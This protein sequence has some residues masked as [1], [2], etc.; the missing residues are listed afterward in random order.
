MEENNKIISISTQEKIQLNDSVTSKKISKGFGRKED[1]IELHILTSDDQL[2]HSEGNFTEYT[3]PDSSQESTPT[4]TYPEIIINPIEVLSKRG[5]V[6]GR[7]KIKL[8]I[9]RKKVFDSSTDPF[10]IKE[11]SPSRKE[12]RI[13]APKVSNEIFD[14][15]VKSFI[16]EIESSAYFRDFVLN[17]GRDIRALGINIL[18]NKN[19]NK[20]ELL[21][22]LL[23]PLP[24][25]I[26]DQTTLNIVE[27]IV[28][29]QI[30]D[31]DLGDPET[32]D[33]SIY[34]R[35]P[36]FKI[37]TRINNSIPSGFKNY[38]D[39]LEY[40]L[41]SSYQRL[42]NQLDNREIPSIDYD[43]VRP[44]SS[45]TED[46]DVTYHFENFVHFSNATERLKN[47]EYKVKLIEI[48]ESQIQSI[49]NVA[50]S[51]TPPTVFVSNGQSSGYADSGIFITD[52]SGPGDLND[53]TSGMIIINSNTGGT[54]VVTSLSNFG[55]IMF[56]NLDT[57]GNLIIQTNDPF[58]VL[59]YA[60]GTSPTDLETEKE[61]LEE[62]KLRLIGGFDGYE[63]F[64]YYETGSFATWPKKVPTETNTDIYVPFGT[65]PVETV[66]MTATNQNSSNQYGYLSSLNIIFADPP[67]G[68]TGNNIQ[69][70]MIIT[71]TTTGES[72][73]IT[74][75]I[76]FNEIEFS[77]TLFIG[78]N[79][80]WTIGT[81]F[82]FHGSIV[83]GGASFITDGVQVGHVINNLTT[84]Q[85]ATITEVN[86]ETEL[87]FS[88]LSYAQ[89]GIPF[90]AGDNFSITDTYEVPIPGGN[91]PP[92]E[93][94]ET[95]SPQA[96]AWLGSADGS[97]PLYGGQLLSASLF[98]K[99]NEHA[100]VNLV[101][102]HIFDNPDNDFYK[103]FV[104]MI[105]HH[106]DG[107]WTYIK[108]YTDINDTHH[109]RGISK[110]LVYFQLKS[111]GIETFD[112]FEN[113]NL[114]EYILGDNPSSTNVPT[115]VGD[116]TIGDDF[117]IGGGTGI[118]TSGN[119]L[120]VPA[121]QTLVTA[122][123]DGSI[124]K[125]DITKEIWKRLYHN[126]PHLLK[127][128]GTERGVKALMSCYGVPSTILNVKEYGGNTVTS[129]P[130]KNLDT[131]DYYKTFTY[132]K[133]SQALKGD[134]GADGF[135]VR[136][137]W[138][139][140]LGSTIT[141]PNY[142]S[143]TDPNLVSAKAHT[144]EFRIKP[145]RTGDDQILMCFSQSY[146]PDIDDAMIN[147]VDGL[148][149]QYM[150]IEPYSGSDILTTDDAPQYGKLVYRK[151]STFLPNTQTFVGETEYFPIYSGEWWNIHAGINIEGKDSG[152]DGG[153]L[154]QVYGPVTADTSSNTFFGAYRA[155]FL[156]NVSYYTGSTSMPMKSHVYSWGVGTSSPIE[157]DTLGG[158]GAPIAFPSGGASYMYICG[159][160]VSGGFLNANTSITKNA[161]AMSYS[162]S[163]QELRYYRGELLTH[164]T[165]IKHALEPFMYGGNSVSS[166]YDN[167]YLRLALGSND[168]QDSSSFH[169]NIKHNYLNADTN[170]QLINTYE[171]GGGV[172]GSSQPGGFT[173]GW[174]KG[175]DGDK[176]TLD[177]DQGVLK[178]SDETTIS[179][180]LTFS[181]VYLPTDELIKDNTYRVR[182]TM[183]NLKRTSSTFST[184]TGANTYF[185]IAPEF[186]A[187]RIYL[188]TPDGYQAMTGNLHHHFHYAEPLNALGD[189]K[190][191]FVPG[192][193]ERMNTPYGA[194]TNTNPPE[195]ILYPDCRLALGYFGL[196]NSS[197]WDYLG[198]PQAVYGEDSLPIP[199]PNWLETSTVQ[200]AN[201]VNALHES[202]FI[203][204]GY[205]GMLTN[206][207]INQGNFLM[208]DLSSNVGIL[209]YFGPSRL[210]AQFEPGQQIYQQMG[211]GFGGDEDPPD[212][213][214]IEIDKEIHQTDLGAD[215]EY[216]LRPQGYAGTG[217]SL[218]NNNQ[219][220][221]SIE[222]V[223]VFGPG[224][225][226]EIS[227]LS[228]E[229]V[230]DVISNLT[231]SQEW[232]ETLENHYHLTPDTV[233]IST[234]SEK[235]RIDEGTVNDDIL[236][237]TIKSED[238]TLDRQPQDFED[239][240]I[241]FSPTTEINEDIMYTLG[242]FRLDDY[243][244][245]PLP[246]AQSASIYEDLK[247]IKDIYFKKVRRNRYNYWDY[248]KL[249]Q[250]VDHT[251]FK[252]IEQFVP[253]KANTKTGLL[254]EPHF[255]E[256]TKFARELPIRSDG[257]TM[258]T[259]SH[260]TFDFQIDPEKAFHLNS[261]SLGGGNAI[262]YAGMVSN[263]LDNNYRFREDI[264]TNGTIN[265]T[266]YILDEVQNAAQG[267]TRPYIPLTYTISLLDGGFPYGNNLSDEIATTSQDPS[268]SGTGLTVLYNSNAGGSVTE[269]SV[270]STGN[271]MYEKGDI[272]TIDGPQ[273]DEFFATFKI[274]N[275]KG[276]NVPEP[277]HKKISSN[278]LLGNA[279]RSRISNIYYR[280]IKH[281]D[282][283]NLD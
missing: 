263:Q 3:F 116:A 95:T 197:I 177:K 102:N 136:T 44:V 193:T 108:A 173:R 64:L 70:G 84:G 207:F 246:S 21:V 96:Q 149:T 236:S 139:S 99:Q 47:F 62:K 238:S 25:S 54:A 210:G 85:S 104:H 39:I 77:E 189:G 29:P 50:L 74:N 221:G 196:F 181:T 20:H 254:I 168:Q 264:G 153:A 224:V 128:K 244:G 42:L 38:N 212:E 147:T 256:R 241:F 179:D 201:F 6:S 37:D 12:V 151:A 22:K 260:Q 143:S 270:K 63:Q 162:G 35:P 43:Y 1:I 57:D 161:N 279:P 32:E 80:D 140:S 243:I 176:W 30:I 5:Y 204:L 56:N 61:K 138:S 242:A 118:D 262:S 24:T 115:T 195:R 83:S 209:G 133:S 113:S 51:G 152:S 240:G 245:S 191:N 27:N 40:N 89:G 107:I 267:P 186:G 282:T 114:I 67:N 33:D 217:P 202:N 34:L 192:N 93:L 94:Y 60:P 180:A 275:L 251:L 13:I 226:Y 166:S 106:F 257:Q 127:T 125:G 225:A 58:E 172:S 87:T 91:L 124:P 261:S 117:I 19:P 156:K 97:S 215:F 164:K 252:L 65:T 250:Y 16:A 237:T 10:S 231:S 229:L 92:Y 227:N 129:G 48:Y 134:A 59:A 137:R 234:T 247:E 277:Y 218:G 73:V 7:L 272:I 278:T 174:L 259:G 79:D 76:D 253:F 53:V 100:L 132:D 105:G 110:D 184:E 17:F 188:N 213:F 274:T 283:L 141:N 187:L 120:P 72:G 239:L 130:L 190:Y 11:I 86:S 171:V 28:D 90:N 109:T 123:N 165:H 175:A 66:V 200:A 75:V 122:S 154:A 220:G 49:E 36:N 119:Y 235:T 167:L 268:A 145:V 144:I 222:I 68:F 232:E 271:G 52:T 276:Y 199:D 98:D 55:A 163:L 233:G 23:N 205:P 211:D 255:L 82:D 158:G 142:N 228:V 185:H 203:G 169:P 148:H 146:A 198:E 9:Q 159:T 155:N 81:P 170:G 131:A 14:R 4:D 126:A 41:T 258:T 2:I 160:A 273:P 78:I 121:G 214:F 206:Q 150:Y 178:Y 216:L 8:N 26:Q 183:K 101:P 18:L 280:I 111:L 45:S 281:Q 31:I 248:I 69:P 223:Q 230:P 15:S 269:V 71:N 103:T 46:T 157:V 135:F 219:T 194:Y 182:F 265:V 266:G 249:V 88:D 112:Q 208:S